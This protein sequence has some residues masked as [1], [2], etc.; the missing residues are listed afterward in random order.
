MSERKL[1]FVV[2]ESLHGS[3]LFRICRVAYPE[4]SKRD[5]RALIL[6]GNISV[7]GTRTSSDKD[8]YLRVNSASAV[9]IH[10][11]SKQ[12]FYAIT[13]AGMPD[14]DV[15]ATTPNFVVF[16]KPCGVSA[17]ACKPLDRQILEYMKQ[18]T[19]PKSAAELL[20][21]PE[22]GLTAPLL[23]ASS[24]SSAR[25]LESKFVSGR[26]QLTY[27]CVVCGQP[28]E[29]PLD[30]SYAGRA[31]T[32]SLSVRRVSRC[33]SHGYLSLIDFPIRLSS[34]TRI[35]SPIHTPLSGS[36]SAHIKSIRRILNQ[37]GFPIVGDHK[38]VKK[39]KGIYA[40]ISNISIPYEDSNDF[41]C[42]IGV[43]AKFFKLLEREE[44][45]WMLN[46]QRE[47]D[48]ATSLMLDR[49]SLVTCDS[50]ENDIENNDNEDDSDDSDNVNDD[51]NDEKEDDDGNDS[52]DQ[53]AVRPPVEYSLGLALFRGLRLRVDPSV[54]IPRRSSEAL[55]EAAVE[56]AGRWLLDPHNR[57]QTLCV[58]DLGTGSGCLLLATIHELIRLYGPAV[59]VRGVGV[60]ISA[61][62][63]RV[64]EANCAALGL[65][66]LCSF[67]EMS[68]DSIQTLQ[69]GAV[70]GSQL[71]EP[72]RPFF[73]VV[74]CNPPYSSKKERSRL[75]AATR[76]FEPA[77]ALF[78]AG[79]PLGSYRLLAATLAPLTAG[80]AENKMFSPSTSFIFEVGHGQSDS[81]TSIFQDTGRF[82]L[83][84]TRR[85]FK[86]IKRC[87]VFKTT[88]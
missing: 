75:S 88:E 48:V 22:K 80:S 71:R 69:E 8:E 41:D 32:L 46:Q 76:Q 57:D 53:G 52:I 47:S 59:R 78:S 50:V 86:G 26:M 42:A 66:A 1:P 77:Q 60:D 63:L 7:D 85:D 82:A 29:G 27:S 6:N 84:D 24:S 73:A 23:C 54:M 15:L 21:R 56:S 37:A 79:G 12:Q 61:D 70:G 13:E 87:L 74:L 83:A 2:P 65:S 49:L 3:K 72:E 9:E 4:I 5:M 64:A 10:L 45:F 67:R 33:R 40:C 34:D 20:Y 18:H 19:L 36:L 31:H 11:E 39:S 30:V 28:E 35:E 38:L 17:G 25:E 51:E 81:V 43:P 44:R 16:M 14:L 68:F 58:L 55:V 62:A